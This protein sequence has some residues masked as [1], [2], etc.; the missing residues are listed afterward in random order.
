MNVF[1]VFLDFLLFWS[2]NMYF[3]FCLLCSLGAGSGG[4]CHAV[5]LCIAHAWAAVLELPFTLI[6]C[7]F[8]TLVHLSHLSFLFLR[9]RPRAGS[10]LFSPLWCSL[11]KW[12]CRTR[13]KN[14]KNYNTCICSLLWVTLWSLIAEFI[15]LNLVFLPLMLGVFSALKTFSGSTWVPAGFIS[16]R[17]D[18]RPLSFLQLSW[19]FILSPRSEVEEDEAII[20]YPSLW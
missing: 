19:P 7:D 2:L 1:H 12:Q 20:Q 17:R 14:K 18:C 13:P 9:H 6:L 15:R 16:C 8:L 11:S 10:F 5:S 4:Y 3:T